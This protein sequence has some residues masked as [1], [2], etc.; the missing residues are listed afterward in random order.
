MTEKGGQSQRKR[1]YTMEA[2]QNNAVGPTGDPIVLLGVI[3]G[4]SA[5]P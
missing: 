5:F 1:K 4:D 3:A 2:R